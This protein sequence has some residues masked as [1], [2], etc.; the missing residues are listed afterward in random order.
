M[1]MVEAPSS[2]VQPRS[3]SRRVPAV[4]R[5]CSL[6]TRKGQSSCRR[7]TTVGTVFPRTVGSR[8]CR[9]GSSARSIL[10]PTDGSFRGKFRVEGSPPTGGPI[11]ARTR[12]VDVDFRRPPAHGRLGNTIRRSFDVDVGSDRGWRCKAQMCEPERDAVIVGEFCSMTCGPARSARYGLR[13]SG[14]AR[15]HTLGQCWIRS[16]FATRP[17]PVQRPF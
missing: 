9:F 13:G 15:L 10:S 8:A 6:T 17:Q 5:P 3:P 4:R 16:A 1:P 14:L 12:C 11:E 2:T 7:S